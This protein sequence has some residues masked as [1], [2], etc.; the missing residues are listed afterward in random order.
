[1]P[2]KTRAPVPPGQ[3]KQVQFS[4][5]I[6][7]HHMSFLDSHSIPSASRLSNIT[8]LRLVCARTLSKTGSM[9]QTCG[10][11]RGL[12]QTV[13]SA[14][15]RTMS[16]CATRFPTCDQIRTT[17][18]PSMSSQNSGTRTLTRTGYKRIAEL[19]GHRR[20]TSHNSSP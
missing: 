11:F 9:P 19:G 15:K 16:A 7:L 18:G 1:V 13:G 10:I 8:A 20:A 2:N 14:T 5:S 4:C 12:R 3:F 6:Q 17:S